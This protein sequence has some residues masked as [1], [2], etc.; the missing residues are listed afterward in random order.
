MQIAHKYQVTTCLKYCSK[1]LQGI[2]RVDNACCILE[3]AR[4]VDD[5]ALERSVIDFIDDHATAVLESE[6]FLHINQDTLEFIL[7]GDTFYA[8][9]VDI[10]KAVDN[11][12]AVHLKGQDMEVNPANKR[13]VMGGAFDCLR[14]PAMS[15]RN[16]VATQFQYGYLTDVE[17]KKISKFI[18]G[19]SEISQDL[20]MSCEARMPRETT[21]VLSSL[22]KGALIEP[23]PGQT[24]RNEVH[25][26]CT[27]DIEL[28]EVMFSLNLKPQTHAECTIDI[29]GNDKSKKVFVKEATLKFTNTTAKF[30]LSPIVRLYSSDTPYKM[31]ISIAVKETLVYTNPVYALS[32]PAFGV[33]AAPSK[34]KQAVESPS[35]PKQAV[36]FLL[37]ASSASVQMFQR[38]SMQTQTEDE[39]YYDGRPIRPAAGVILDTND[40]RN[41]FINGIRYT[42]KSNR[43]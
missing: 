20:P 17:E 22:L 26:I 10:I 9:E 35:K 29:L 21:C 23:T 16:F 14:L 18:I 32:T 5:K 34:P 11:W 38:R 30:T 33:F 19:L 40:G 1:F 28:K 6:G 25:L 15:L 39:I 41:S 13:N 24:L 8:K 7:Q 27:R 36:G 3:T 2:V 4:L 12:S 43:A 42:N 37:G 31:M